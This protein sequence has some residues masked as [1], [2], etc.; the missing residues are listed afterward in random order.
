MLTKISFFKRL[1]IPCQSRKQRGK[2]DEMGKT[3]CRSSNL[4][5]GPVIGLAACLMGISQP[6]KALELEDNEP[7]SYAALKGFARHLSSHP[8]QAP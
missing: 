7:F 1:R 6:A 2:K 5:S 8:Y 3:V 4:L